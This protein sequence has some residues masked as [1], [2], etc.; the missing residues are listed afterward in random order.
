MGGVLQLTHQ[1]LVQ[2]SID[3]LYM[4][5]HQSLHLWVQPFGMVSSQRALLIFSNVPLASLFHCNAV[6]LTLADVVNSLLRGNTCTVSAQLLQMM[7]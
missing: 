5:I 1:L 6:A 4:R 2:L 7:V 3:I